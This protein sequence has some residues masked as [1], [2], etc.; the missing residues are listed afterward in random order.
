MQHWICEIF[1]KKIIIYIIPVNDIM[2]IISD[3]QGRLL[4]LYSHYTIRKAQKTWN[5]VSDLEH[6]LYY[7]VHELQD[8]NLDSFSSSP[9][10]K[11]G[12]TP[13]EH[14]LTSCSRRLLKDF[15]LLS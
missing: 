13:V 14:V 12:L 8:S 10:N 11:I 9:V 2:K 1:K 15:W 5:I 4:H 6:S 7:W 3:I